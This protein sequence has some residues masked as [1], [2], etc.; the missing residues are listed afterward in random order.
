MLIHEEFR[1]WLGQTDGWTD[2]QTASLKKVVHTK[3][4]Y[5]TTRVGILFLTSG[6]DFFAMICING[7]KN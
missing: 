3:K 1:F 5:R 2:G 7:D 6:T 4:G